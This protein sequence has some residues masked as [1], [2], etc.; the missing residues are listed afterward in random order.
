MIHSSQYNNHPHHHH[1]LSA[2]DDFGDAMD[3]SGVLV[4]GATNAMMFITGNA[5]SLPFHRRSKLFQY[6]ILKPIIFIW[7]VMK[8]IKPKLS[9]RK[10]MDLDD[11]FGFTTHRGTAPPSPKNKRH[12]H[13]HSNSSGGGGH[14]HTDHSTHSSSSR[15]NHHHHQQPQIY[16]I[17][18]DIQFSHIQS[19]VERDIYRQLDI[20]ES[21]YVPPAQLCIAILSLIFIVVFG[22]FAT[23]MLSSQQWWK[24][25]SFLKSFAWNQSYRLHHGH[26]SGQGGSGSGGGLGEYAS[27]YPNHFSQSTGRPMVKE[28]IEE[29]F[30]TELMGRKFQALQSSRSTM[31]AIAKDLFYGPLGM[32]C[33]VSIWGTFCSLLFFGR[34][35]L[36][37]PDLA[38][39]SGLMTGKSS[40]KSMKSKK[41]EKP[42]SETYKPISNHDSDRFTLYFVVALLRIIENVILCVILPQTEY[43]CKATG[44]CYKDTTLFELNSVPGMIGA[45]SRSMYDGLVKD[46]VSIMIVGI[47]VVLVTTL[48]LLAQAVALDKSFLALK[49]YVYFD[50]IN[51]GTSKGMD[52]SN[53]SGSSSGSTKKGG[54]RYSSGN[55]NKNDFSFFGTREPMS[56]KRSTLKY[57]HELSN[58]VYETGVSMFTNELGALSSSRILAVCS[59]IHVLFS[60]FLIVVWILYSLFGKNCYALVLT[61][62]AV[63]NSAGA[64][65]IGLVEFDELESIAKE[66]SI[67]KND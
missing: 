60:L 17:P 7:T 22:T 52:G 63:F 56:W 37:I 59:H 43:A 18:D 39:R 46:W 67:D 1:A 53:T 25:H 54:K 30:D 66:I 19:Q 8:W 33:M 26:G 28:A 38:N 57:L 41:E 24:K 47:S 45:T 4:G 5:M 62:I 27:R 49:S 50:S 31:N 55:D 65:E 10:H 44:H 40:N 16:D 64:M 9:S 15:S 23:K 6:V 35:L 32:L 2:V 36:P 51:G 12:H 34:I 20:L 11:D 42:W 58:H 48:I 14:S 61:F 21:K 3:D 29:H 13:H